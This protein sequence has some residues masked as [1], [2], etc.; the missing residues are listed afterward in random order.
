MNHFLETSWRQTFDCFD[1][2]ANGTLSASHLRHAFLSL[3]EDQSEE[4]ITANLAIM[5]NH[6]DVN[7]DFHSFLKFVDP[8]QL[9]VTVDG[10]QTMLSTI[11]IDRSGYLTAVKLSNFLANIGIDVCDADV[12]QMLT[13]YNLNGN[14]Q[15]SIAEF[16]KLLFS[17]GYRTDDKSVRTLQKAERKW[18]ATEDLDSSKQIDLSAL[19]GDEF[20]A[21]KLLDLNNSGTVSMADP[22]TAAE[23]LKVSTNNTV[24][25]FVAKENHSL[26]WNP[27]LKRRGLSQYLRKVEHKARIVNDVGRSARF[28]SKNLGFQQIRRPNFDKHGAWFSMG[29]VELHLIKGKPVVASGDDLIVN[30]ISLETSEIEKIPGE[31]ERLGIPFRQNVSVPKG[32]DS[33][34]EGTNTSKNSKEIVEQYFLR[35]PDGYYMEICNCHVMT[36]YCLGKAKE[37]DGFDQNVKPLTLH[38]AAISINVIQDWA[39]VARKQVRNQSK[40]LRGGSTSMDGSIE[41][42]AFHIGCTAAKKANGRIWQNLNV[43]R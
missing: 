9:T 24:S 10:V 39:Q 41:Q 33:G 32:R 36:T 8:Y 14:N 38:T 18:N 29:N 25:S 1:F 11:D 15:I 12:A 42:I 31:L 20:H 22:I 21:L 5:R 7:I 34:T 2:Y 19:S 6:P 30:H 27:N 3:G 40:T 37:M 16:E 17:M 43:R 4:T 35:D 23:L 26:H 13:M 28:Y